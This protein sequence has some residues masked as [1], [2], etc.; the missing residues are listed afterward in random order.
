VLLEGDTAALPFEGDSADAIF[1]NMVL[2][3]AEDPATM[4]AEMARVAK[5]GGAVAITYEVEHP[6]AWMHEEHADV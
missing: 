6:F 5:P 1:A 4:L 3:H 2:H